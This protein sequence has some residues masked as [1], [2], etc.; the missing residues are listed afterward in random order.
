MAER[1]MVW[2]AQRRFPDAVFASVGSAIVHVIV[3]RLEVPSKWVTTACGHSGFH[4]DYIAEDDLVC[5]RCVA[6]LAREQEAG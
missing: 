6:K 1:L 4:E 3:Q 5:M 2:R